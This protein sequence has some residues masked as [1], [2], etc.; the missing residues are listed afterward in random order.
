[1]PDARIS[2]EAESDI[3]EI[4]DS[5]LKLDSAANKVQSSV[6]KIG[7][8]V[9]EL[10]TS[11]IKLKKNLDITETFEIDDVIEQVD[12]LIEDVK[13]LPKVYSK[14]VLPDMSMPF[15]DEGWTPDDIKIDWI[16]G[17][18]DDLEDTIL[19]EMEDF[20]KGVKNNLITDVEHWFT[21]ETPGKEV[22]GTSMGFSTTDTKLL[23]AQREANSKEVTRESSKSVR[24]GKG[25]TKAAKGLFANLSFDKELRIRLFLTILYSN[26]MRKL[27]LRSISI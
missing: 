8:S 4:I 22:T 17:V 6:S 24:T 13:E 7:D 2:L 1:M 23:K 27:K 18:F 16:E 25:L 5:F 9:N 14:Y 12:E 10:N 15:Y 3:S 26:G 19:T 11:A 20:S 21:P